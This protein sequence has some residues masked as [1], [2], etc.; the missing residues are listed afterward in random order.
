M[1]A[2]HVAEGLK[3]GSGGERES[4]GNIGVFKL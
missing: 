1:N 2:R 4:H 3:Y